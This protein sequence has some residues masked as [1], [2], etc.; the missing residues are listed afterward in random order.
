MQQSD[1]F[2]ALA[3]HLD[4][5][6]K[7]L[8]DLLLDMQ[9]GEILPSELQWVK[10]YISENETTQET[11]NTVD[12]YEQWQADAVL[13]KM[14]NDETIS[15]SEYEL[16]RSYASSRCILAMAEPIRQWEMRHDAEIGL[17]ITEHN[18]RVDQGTC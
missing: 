12:E 7:K 2:N 13:S 14:I 15:E 6:R 5:D 9:S 16:A 17:W 10:K 3:E 1:I 4:P 18:A 11:R 8:N